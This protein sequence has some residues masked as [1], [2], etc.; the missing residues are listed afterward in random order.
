MFVDTHCHLNSE[1]LINEFNDII[2]KAQGNGV[3]FF[4][5]VG[6]DVNSSKK[7]IELSTKHEKV[8]SIVGIHPCDI[9]NSNLDELELLLNEAKVVALGEIGLDYHWVEEKEQREKQKLY[10]IKQIELANKYH[11][12]ISIH[13][14]DALQ[15]TF[16]ILK[17]HRPLYGFI[18]HCYSGSKEMMREF[19]KLGAYISFA[20]PVTF[21][22]AVAGKECA[23]DV[24]FDRIL[25][26]TDCP[27][28]TPHPHRGKRN[29][30]SYIP[31]IYKEIAELR[32]IDVSEL[33]E[34]VYENTLRIFNL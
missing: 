28:L 3:N 34:K 33:E 14:R 7:A 4:A 17:E 16:N 31:L 8:Y 13:S 11:L 10:F 18:M 6:W 21:K 9:D 32:Q 26:E 12:P 2:L 29:D 20:G 24:P 15:D 25:I 22:N 1:D 23:I 30:P 27:Y 19:I 5:V